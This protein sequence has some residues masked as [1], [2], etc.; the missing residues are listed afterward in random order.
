MIRVVTVKH[1]IA[2]ESRAELLE[3][4]LSRI[5][6]DGSTI[7]HITSDTEG[8]TIVYKENSKLHS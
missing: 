7:L 5:D 6:R 3:V 4:E 2:F 8:Y 1:P